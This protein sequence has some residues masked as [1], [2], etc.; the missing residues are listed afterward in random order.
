MVMI[1]PFRALRPAASLAERVASLPYDVMN[2]SEAAVMAEGNPY[3]FLHISRAEIDLPLEI[4]DHAPE[5]YQ[6]SRANL[7]R[8]EQE[9][10]LVKEAA[11]SYYI[12]RLIMDGQ[13]QTGLV[14]CTAVDDYLEGRIKKHEFTR[15]V[16]EQDRIDHFAACGCHTEAVLLTY[17]SDDFI[18][19]ALLDWADGHPAEY[20]FTTDDGITHQFWVLNDAALTA[21]IQK[22]FAEN[23]PALY[24]ADGHHRSASAAK[25]CQ[26]YRAQHP[27]YTGEEAFNEFL[28]VIFPHDQ[29]RIMD[30]NRVV[31]DLGGYTTEAFLHKLSEHFTVTPVA[32]GPYHPEAKH[33]FGLYLAESWYKLEAHADIVP[34]DVTEGL[35]AAILQNAVLAPL[36]GIT[37]PRKDDRIDFVGGIRGLEELER[38]CRNDMQLAFALYPTDI[39]DVLRVAD[40]GQVMPAKSTWFEPK[41]RSGLFL[42]PLEDN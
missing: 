5:V 36:L 34:D 35:D 39:N 11:P 10:I 27:D 12:Y 15:P 42:H 33:T 32:N 28:A 22:R 14:G 8:F 37:D 20:D 31:K 16:K 23:V 41:L 25:V 17:R 9:G 21:E 38:R 4:D 26:A 40:S 13:A 3:S 1:S 7:E 19:Q 6:K 2:R 18:D 30:Y 29:L 24:I